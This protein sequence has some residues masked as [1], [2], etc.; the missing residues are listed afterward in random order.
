MK[1]VAP[2]GEHRPALRRTSPASGARSTATLEVSGSSCLRCPDEPCIRFGTLESGGGNAIAVC[3]VDAI[4]HARSDGGP[5]V[6]ESCI[7]CG[8]CAVRC[9]VGAL[10]F[11]FSGRVEVIPPDPSET[12]PVES[13]VE[14]Y[15]CRSAETSLVEWPQ[16]VWVAL[17]RRM[18]AAAIDLKQIAFY[19]LVAHL[20]T[21]AGLPAWRPAQ[22]DTSNRIDLILIDENDSLPVEVK[23]R[24]E[25][26]VINVKSV[27]Q[28][29]ENR[30]VLDERAFSAA[31][32]NS[33]TLVVG[34]DYPP[35]RSDVAALI[36]DIDAA[37][38]IKVGMISLA[39]LCELALR[40]QLAGEE[41]PRAALAELKGRFR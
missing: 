2:D 24:T 32:R 41:V 26:P 22:G 38:N 7:G 27:Q 18:A 20:F 10:R 30:I 28:A 34:Y 33:S 29:L 8:L 5:V 12:T 13:D 35:E 4:H 36:D 21:A 31:D 25:S 15:G 19:P 14:F 9:P 16:Q 17:A 6:S 40:R 39:H 37:F 3:P 11:T 1:R 23:S